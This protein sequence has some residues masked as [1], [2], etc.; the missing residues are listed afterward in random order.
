MLCRCSFICSLFHLRMCICCMRRV[1]SA[2]TTPA[3]VVG[4]ESFDCDWSAIPSGGDPEGFLH[5]GLCQRLSVGDNGFGLGTAPP[6]RPCNDAGRLR[7]TELVEVGLVW[8]VSKDL[9]IVYSR[10]SD[11]RALFWISMH[12]LSFICICQQTRLHQQHT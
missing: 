12:K 11:N 10:D 5:A 7:Q 3:A 6:F 4:T 8:L 9:L 2:S 1:C